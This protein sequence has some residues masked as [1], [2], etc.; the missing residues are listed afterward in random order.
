MVESLLQVVSGLREV[1]QH[2]VSPDRTLRWGT[3][4]AAWWS[5]C[6]RRR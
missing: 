4:K 1:A 5:L 3:A 2:Q 6:Q